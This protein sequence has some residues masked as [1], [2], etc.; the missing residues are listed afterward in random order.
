VLADVKRRKKWLGQNGWVVRKAT[1]NKSMRV[2]WIDG[3]TSLEINYYQKSTDK[4]QIVVQHSKLPNASA[5]A[6]MKVF[7]SKMLDRLKDMLES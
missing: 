1:P 2:T 3:E 6:K 5:A 4:S 7:W